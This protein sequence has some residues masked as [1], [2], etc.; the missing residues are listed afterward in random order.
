MI[1]NKTVGL[2]CLDTIW[3]NKT[4]SAIKKTLE[5][6][7]ADKIYWFSDIPIPEK[8]DVPI[9]WI[10]ISKLKK[11]TFL[12]DNGQIYTKLMPSVI[13]T[14][15]A[16]Y[17][18]S[19][20]FVVNKDSWDD[21]FLEYDYIGAPW[22]FY[23][24]EENVGNGGFCIKSKKLHEAILSLNIPEDLFYEYPEDNIICRLFRKKLEK[25]FHIK[26]APEELACK[27]SMECFYNYPKQ[28]YNYWVGKSLG[29]HG[30]NFCE[31]YGYK[32]EDLKG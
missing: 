20:G 8:F 31:Y 10:E 1:N 13:D 32:F 29:F 27:F 12:Y 15:F 7:S 21:R 3:Y 17:I 30:I 2:V 14:D 22:P 18:H 26:F 28:S 9:E 16:M 23:P 11:E 5:Y 19:D 24:E 25:K 6:V 4:I